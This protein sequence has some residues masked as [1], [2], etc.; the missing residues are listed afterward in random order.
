TIGE[1]DAVF[2][3]FTRDRPDALFVGPD[4]FFSSRAVQFALLAARDRIPAT[5]SNRDTVEAGGPMSYCNKLA[6][7]VVQ[8]GI[9]SGRILKGETPSTCRCRNRPNSCSPSICKRRA[10]SESKCRQMCSRSP[11][12]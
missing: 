9:Y 2:A 1:I 6:E 10:R 11:T 4:G 5:Y 12:R 3:G 7:T 8:V